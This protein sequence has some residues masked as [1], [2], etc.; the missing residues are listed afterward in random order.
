M[1]GV[2]EGVGQVVEALGRNDMLDNT[3]IFFSS[4]NGGVPYA[5]ANNRPF[6]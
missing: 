5:G 6:R 2:D 4:D 1:V 3:I